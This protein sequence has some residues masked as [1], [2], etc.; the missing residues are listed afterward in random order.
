MTKT[1]R[2]SFA[3]ATLGWVPDQKHSAS[4]TLKGGKLPGL[5]LPATARFFPNDVGGGR[6]SISGKKGESRPCGEVYLAKILTAAEAEQAAQIDRIT[7]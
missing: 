2:L 7:F 5:I 3:L 1:K 6:L 4:G